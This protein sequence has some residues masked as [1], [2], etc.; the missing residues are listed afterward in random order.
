MNLYLIAFALVASL[1]SGV[2]GYSKGYSSGFEKVSAKW[3]EE[4]AVLMEEHAANLAKARQSEQVA[5]QSASKLRQEKVHALQTIDALG[6]ALR[7]S[8]R[9]RPERS[10][11]AADSSGMPE[12]SGTCR[13]ATGAQLARGDADFLIGYGSDA[14]KLAKELDHCVS[15]YNYMKRYFNG[16]RE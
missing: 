16:E 2:V 11:A 14:A 12:G 6:N 4:K 13:A 15:Q 10:I 5:Q 9:D 8:V 1:I 7:D 3:A